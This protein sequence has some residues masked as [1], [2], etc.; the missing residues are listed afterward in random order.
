MKPKLAIPMHYATFPT[1][2]KSAD[3]FVY[4]AGIVAPEVKV[5]VLIPGQELDIGL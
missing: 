5:R 4:T 2:V 1:L 3:E